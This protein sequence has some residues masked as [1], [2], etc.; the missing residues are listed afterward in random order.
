MKTLIAF[1]AASLACTPALAKA[2]TAKSTGK[3]PGMV[4][5]ADPR[6]ARELPALQP[7]R[8]RLPVPASA[9]RRRQHPVVAA[10]RGGCSAGGGLGGGEGAGALGGAVPFLV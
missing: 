1:A 2:P 7:R 5:A 9:A 6:A 8:V 4:S 10:R 3:V